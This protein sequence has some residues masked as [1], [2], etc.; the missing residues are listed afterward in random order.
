MT[1]WGASAGVAMDVKLP[2]V[3][4]P[5]NRT[6]V[7]DLWHELPITEV[8]GRNGM[9]FRDLGRRNRLVTGALPA[10]NKNPDRMRRSGS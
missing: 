9:N 10:S 8:I 5:A 6:L 7:V 3:H 4:V 2:E 1:A